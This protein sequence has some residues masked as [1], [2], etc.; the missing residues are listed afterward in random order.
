MK[1]QIEGLQG[2]ERDIAESALQYGVALLDGKL[3]AKEDL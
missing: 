3:D 1:E 2:E